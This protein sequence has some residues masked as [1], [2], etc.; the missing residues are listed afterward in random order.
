MIRHFNYFMKKLWFGLVFLIIACNSKSEKRLPDNKIKMKIHFKNCSKKNLL[1]IVDEEYQV[2][3]SVSM[4]SEFAELIIPSD[5]PQKLFIADQKDLFKSN[6]TSFHFDRG[7]NELFI[8][9]SESIDSIKIK[10][11]KIN[12]EHLELQQTKWAV[13]EALTDNLNLLQSH[14]ALLDSTVLKKD[15]IQDIIEGLELKHERLIKESLE[16]ELDY[17]KDK[18]NS[19]LAAHNLNIWIMNSYATEYIEVFNFLNQNLSSEIKKTSKAIALNS[20]INAFYNNTI[21]M[22]IREFNLVDI[23][24]SLIKQKDFENNYLLIDFWASWC[25]P[26]IEDFPFL[27]DLK[28]SNNIAILSLSL[29]TDMEAWKSAILKYKLDNF[30][31]I[32][33]EQNPQQDIKSEFFVQAIPVKI[34][35]NPN[36]VIIGR[37]R[38]FDQTHHEDILNLIN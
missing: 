15:S 20:K 30:V 22:P 28:N 35:V 34:L 29:D 23:S 14:V 21:G 6:F 26:C 31:H 27:K 1:Y 36:G 7:V 8:D 13:N 4:K 2:L 33:L 32:S 18:P 19:Y 9:C 16:I 12:E 24:G 11:S 5:N 3:D 37:W 17:F 10:G 38:G 25:L